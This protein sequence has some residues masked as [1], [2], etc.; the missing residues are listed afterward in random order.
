MIL[1]TPYYLDSSPDRQAELDFC[2]Q[3]NIQNP[4]IA[5]VVLFLD[6]SLNA[7]QIEELNHSKIEINCCS[8]RCT[9]QDCLDYANKYFQGEIILIANTDI[10]FDNTLKLLEDHDLSNQFITLSRWD[11][12]EVTESMIYSQLRV[13]I[14]S[15][16]AWIFRAPL[17]P[18]SAY[19]PLGKPGCDNRIA[20]EAHTVGLQVINPALSI[21]SHHLHL[22]GVRNYTAQ[23]Q[24]PGPYLLVLPSDQTDTN[25]DYIYVRGDAKDNAPLI[26]LRAGELIKKLPTNFNCQIPYRKDFELG[27]LGKHQKSTA[28]LTAVVISRNS[29]K[30]LDITLISLRGCYDQLLVIDVG[31]TDNTLLIARRYNAQIVS[32]AEDQEFQ[33]I[34]RS[35]E[36]GWIFQLEADEFIDE[37]TQNFLEQFRKEYATEQTRSDC[38]L[39]P[40]RWIAPWNTTTYLINE[41][42]NFDLQ[43]RLFLHSDQLFLVNQ[44]SNFIGGFSKPYSELN[45]ARIYSLYLTTNE[46]SLRQKK[47]L[48]NNWYETRGETL[49]LCMPELQ[50]MQL[51]L[52][53]TQQFSVA[54]I[55]LLSCL[56]PVN[57]DPQLPLI[58]CTSKAYPVIVVDGVF[59]QYSKSGIGRV[60]A[61][62]LEE[63]VTTGFA[64]HLVVIDRGGT[65]PKISGVNYRTAPFY[66]YSQALVGREFNEQVC[67][68]EQASLFTSSYY[69]TPLSCR[70]AFMAYDMIPEVQG[71][72][73]SMPVWQAKRQAIGHASIYIAISENTASDLTRLFPHISS[74]EVCV[75]HCGVDNHFRTASSEQIAQFKATW[76]IT[77]PYFLIVGN[78]IQYKNFLLFL[79]AFSDLPNREDFSIVCI[80]GTSLEA[81]FQS[82]AR[83]FPIHMLKLSDQELGVAYSGAVALIYPSL[84]EGF[85]MPVAE[86]MAC[87]CPVIT[88]KNSSLVEVGAEAVLYV[89]ETDVEGMIRALQKVQEPTIRRALVEAGLEQVKRFSWSRMAEKVA[90]VLLKATLP[91]V[92]A[93][94]NHL[95]FP[96]WEQENIVE[97]LTE[98]LAAWIAHSPSPQTALL[99][100]SEDF[101][102]ES[103]MNAEAFL[104]GI[105]TELFFT[106]GLAIEN[107]IHLLPA[108]YPAQWQL[109]LKENCTHIPMALENR[110]LVTQT[111]AHQLPKRH[112]RWD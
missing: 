70:S 78:R 67:Q 31:S 14:D 17:K 4:L 2:I 94:E 111:G 102:A 20:F 24:I 76:G 73:L 95:L 87:S 22:T 86:A 96:D 74:P 88:C 57:L 3:M 19:I 112:S 110:A 85:G 90:H 66:D 100:T 71:W 84:Y 103:E 62:L 41:P 23:E 6:N 35:V 7:H 49:Y 5:K 101:P 39:I 89:G 18:F 36:G 8:R 46:R 107:P 53:D 108:L 11:V 82:F 83:Q 32:V 106:R 105:L 29:E 65:T 40:R 75:A 33:A 48:R 97:E 69:T 93:P 80:G 98:I 56:E 79:F 51:T 72:G 92:P 47:S 68:E 91:I 55:D 109:L 27:N 61:T 10:F 37:Q 44:H 15:Q 59:F 28:G 21:R 12:V 64:H 13:S 34:L 50:K 26:N 42:H 25:S 16:D 1:I 60:W 54:V 45:C 30:T 52:V 77:K 104:Q 63:W 81:E 38:Y 99:I 9:Y 58:T 43:L